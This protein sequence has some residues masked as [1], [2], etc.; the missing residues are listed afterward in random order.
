[1]EEAI[2]QSPGCA[3]AVKRGE[4][5][6]AASAEKRLALRCG[7]GGAIPRGT[8]WRGF[9]RRRYTQGMSLTGLTGAVFLC[10]ALASWFPE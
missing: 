7:P 8:R 3:N 2:R 4:L 5:Y 10:Y 9:E 1:M 6:S